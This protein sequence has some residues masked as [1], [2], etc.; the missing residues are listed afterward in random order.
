MWQQRV[1]RDGAHILTEGAQRTLRGMIKV[2]C[3]DTPLDD[4]DAML[5]LVKP[6]DAVEGSRSNWRRELFRSRV[7]HNYFLCVWQRK[8]DTWLVA[9]DNEGFVRRVIIRGLQDEQEAKVVRSE[10]ARRAG[11]EKLKLKPADIERVA[12]EVVSG[13]AEREYQRTFRSCV[14]RI[15]DYFMWRDGTAVPS[16]GYILPIAKLL[17]PADADLLRVV[18]ERL[19]HANVDPNYAEDESRARIDLEE[20]CPTCGREP[21][22]AGKRGTYKR[23]ADLLKRLAEFNDEY[24]RSVFDSW[25]GQRLAEGKGTL[26]STLYR[27]YVSWAGKHGDNRAERRTS[28]ETLLTHNKW[29][30]LMAARFARKRSSRG[31]V[32]VGVALR[33]AK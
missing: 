28:E 17:K 24:P 7:H 4:M 27:D 10:F 3:D 16:D 25:R 14:A 19:P 2:T 20:R 5:A 8:R 6:F 22:E 12:R 9:N 11:R 33:G 31:D 13:R 30:R 29:G 1:S 21:Q 18:F 23:R 26:S 32:Y 15:G